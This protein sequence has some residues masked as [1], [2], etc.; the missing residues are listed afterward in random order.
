MRDIN[1]YTAE[2]FRR[3]EKKLKERKR[4]R[5]RILA[6]SIPMCL[7]I[8]LC[9]VMNLPK[10]LN[11]NMNN[12]PNDEACEN[13]AGE[14]APELSPTEASTGAQNNN[15]SSQLYSLNA[16]DSFSFSLT[17]NCYG[18]SSYNSETGELIKTTDATHP[19]DYI[20]T[21]FLTD[22]QKLEIYNLITD[23]N[24]ASYPDKYDPHGDGLKS[25]PSMTLILTVKDH[26]SEKT[27]AA[28]DIALTFES[29]N[30]AGQR[31]LSTC[32]AIQNILTSTDAW[33]AL[34]DYEFLYE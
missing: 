22:E 10:M 24:M 34:P 4:K 8:T 5:S 7:I 19:E 12:A 30:K 25:S 2:V 28:E 20:T 27:I 26:I 32:E 1:E 15:S 3:S 33:Q 16:F 21:Y 14:S 31:F 17:W 9:L 18:V 11:E 23:L 29:D 13:L 6:M